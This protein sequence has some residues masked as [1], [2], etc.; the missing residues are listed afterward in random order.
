MATRQYIGARYVPIFMGTWDNQTVYEPLSIVLYMNGSYT[1]K[2]A[3]PS[4]TLPTNTEYWA[5]TGNYNGQI[6]EY[7]QEVS[8]LS[9]DL[10]A[11]SG[12]VDDIADDV[13][14]LSDDISGVSSDL[15]SFESATNDN[16]DDLEDAISYNAPSNLRGKK[17]LMIGDSYATGSQGIAGQG[18][19][20]YLDA[21]LG[22]DATIAANSGAGFVDTGSTGEYNGMAFGDMLT[23]EANKLTAAQRAEYRAVICCGGINDYNEATSPNNAVISFVTNARTY[24]P[25]ARIFVLPLFCAS[26]P[27]DHNTSGEA[28]DPIKTTLYRIFRAASQAGACTTWKGIFWLA[29]NSDYAGNSLHPNDAGYQMIAKRLQGFIEGGDADYYTGPGGVSISQ[30]FSTGFAF[31][32][33]LNNRVHIRVNATYNGTLGDANE[34]LFTVTALYRPYSRIW[35][36]CYVYSTNTRILT[37]LYLGT[38]GTIKVMPGTINGANITDITNP[39]FYFDF[40][41][42]IDTM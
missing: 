21:Y 29:G 22:C 14:G 10:T 6:E 34:T 30:N 19:C 5:L 28:T 7:R 13:S 15:E 37:E 36:P 42:M 31:G 26:I 17:V 39:H 16:I 41:Y 38:D 24:Y 11:L 20:Y 8:G 2:K 18:W 1:S 3:V 27:Y 40:D 12:T 23:H 32:E 33:R 35:F 9:D 4:G 25:N